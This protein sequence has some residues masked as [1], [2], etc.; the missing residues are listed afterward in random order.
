MNYDEVMLALK[1]MEEYV[2]T[3]QLKSL[4]K[5]TEIKKRDLEIIRLRKY[6]IYMTAAEMNAADKFQSEHCGKG[7]DVHF[8]IYNYPETD[9]V[10][11]KCK[12]GECLRFF[13]DA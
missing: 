9:I 4:N 1:G 12:C 10:D 7:H 6:G 5:D 8:E 2:R 11:V 3:E 13:H